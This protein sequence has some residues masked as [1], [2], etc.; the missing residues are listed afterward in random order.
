MRRSKI[1]FRG[2]RTPR[3]EIV[4][5]CPEDKTYRQHEARALKKALKVKKLT[6]QYDRTS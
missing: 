4:T 6:P 3:G 1:H 5:T 2:W